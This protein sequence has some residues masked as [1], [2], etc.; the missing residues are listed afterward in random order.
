M[1]RFY[2]GADGVKRLQEW[3]KTI[4]D[5]SDHRNWVDG[6]WVDVPTEGKCRHLR[7]P[8][9]EICGEC[10]GTNPVQSK[11]E[12]PPAKAARE[13]WIRDSGSGKIWTI[14]ETEC[15]AGIHGDETIHVREIID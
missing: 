6:F 1:I 13:W 8:V 3:C 5:P 9:T 4:P 7:G 10:Y 11:P 15:A 14:W 12:Q 2:I